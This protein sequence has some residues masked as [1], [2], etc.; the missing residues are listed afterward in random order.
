MAPDPWSFIDNPPSQDSRLPPELLIR[1]FEYLAIHSSPTILLQI[2]RRWA[3]IASSISSLWSR[4]DLST[5][6]A[7]LLQRCVNRPIEVI[8]PPSLVTPTSNQ[9]K[10]AKEVLRLHSDRICKL[11]LDLPAGHLRAIEPEVSG[12]FP[13]LAD[14]SISV[15][16]DRY[17][18]LDI[19][20]FPEW[21]PVATLPS[22]V[23][24][25]RLL[26]VNT[27]WIPGRFHNLVE[28]FLHD[29][30]YSNLDPTIEVFLRILESSPQLTVLSVANAGPRLP[31]DTTALPPA[32][33][34]V[35]LRNLQLLYLEQEDA[36][37]I[38]WILIHLKIPALQM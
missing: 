4:I 3:G 33:C 10:A 2:C 22:P 29:Q 26:L 28:F 20:D 12:V 11:V 17:G 27:P 34:V 36:C 8:L 24:Y 35:H 23:R 7:P 25:L 31:L 15:R 30:W 14:V 5:P 32:T 19:I 9:L 16:H 1:I 21:K 18:S 37:D 13:I 6:P 38:G